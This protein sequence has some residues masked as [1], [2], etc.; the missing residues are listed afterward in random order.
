MKKLLV[1]V[2]LLFSHAAMADVPLSVKIASIDAGRMISTEDTSVERAE[3]LLS[4]A[5][6]CFN[7]SPQTVADMA[8]SAQNLF[9]G[10]SGRHVIDVID[11]ALIM[12][13]D[14]SSVDTLARVLSKYVSV[15]S[16][17]GVSHHQ[18]VRSLVLLSSKP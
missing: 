16:E 10:D 12:C 4:A 2:S 8:V 13:G 18:A 6:K 1:I 17:L 14:G 5:A 3:V 9:T 15:R 7:T 11:G